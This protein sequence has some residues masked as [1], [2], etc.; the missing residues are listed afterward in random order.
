[1]FRGF[2]IPNYQVTGQ[3]IKFAS[4]IVEHQA[5][6]IRDSLEDYLLDRRRLNGSRMQDDWFPQID[7]DVFISHS[8][9]DL[10]AACDLAGWLQRELGLTAFVD[11]AV[12]RYG[13]SLLRAIDDKYCLNAGEGTY[14]YEKRNRSTAHVH[15]ML[16]VAL[17]KMID[18]CE[19]LFLLN[20][21]KSI[22]TSEAVTGPVTESPWIYFE[23]A[24]SG[25]V[26]PRVPRRGLTKIAKSTSESAIRDSLTIVHS[27]DLHHLSTLTREDILNWKRMKEPGEHGL[28][29]L[30]RFDQR[31]KSLLG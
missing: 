3:S 30:Y 8:H 24:L 4:E 21:P 10:E 28:D 11:A 26:A 27:V 29:A 22:T 18:H 7:A 31:R 14:S 20:T 25:L 6:Q 1:M 9:Q 12:W 19:G 2:K 15:M 16:A 17:A 13:D 23:T 5:K